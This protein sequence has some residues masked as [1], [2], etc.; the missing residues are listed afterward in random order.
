[1]SDKK[2]MLYSPQQLPSGFR[3]PQAFVD[4]ATSGS[5]PEIYPWW[6]IDASTETGEGLFS[7]RQR[8]GR[9]L[10]PFA[11]VDADLNDIACFNGDD[12]SGNPAVLMLVLDES[13]RSYSFKDFEEWLAFATAYAADIENFLGSS[14]F[15][16]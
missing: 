8:D 2:L 14:G 5:L 11:K 16:S 9:N 7:R 15:N 13:G 4:M 10:I 1:M 6:F 3:Y 12:T